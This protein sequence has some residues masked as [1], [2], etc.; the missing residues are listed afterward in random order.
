MQGGQELATLHAVAMQ[1]SV[2]S[3]TCIQRIFSCRGYCTLG[4]GSNSAVIGPSLH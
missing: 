3:S 1:G 4:S 2:P